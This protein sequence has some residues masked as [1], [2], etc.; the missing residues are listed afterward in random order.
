M[1]LLA[2]C[3]IVSCAKSEN[4]NGITPSSGEYDVYV[5]GCIGNYYDGDILQAV[6]W[7][8]AEIIELGEGCVE[9]ICV[10][11]KDVYALGYTPDADIVL[12]KNGK[13]II[14]EGNDSPYGAREMTIDNGKVYIVGNYYNGDDVRPVYWVNGERKEIN[15]PKYAMAYSISVDNNDIY[16]AGDAKRRAVVW[17]NGRNVVLDG[18][19]YEVALSIFANNNDVYVAGVSS[20][21][22]EEEDIALLW[23]NG[24]KIELD[25]GRN[26][27]ATG[28]FESNAN[29]YVSGYD[30]LGE[31]AV[32]W[33]N[34]KKIILSGIKLGDIPMHT[35]YVSGDEVFLAAFK[36][37]YDTEDSKI[38]PVLWHNG[39]VTELLDW[40]SEGMATSVVA[41]PR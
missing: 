13:K 20:D 41:V 9:S 40:T 33:K 4:N 8:N 31:S 1:K 34:N 12:W 23:K 24:R 26:C 7:K 21:Y 22:Q 29:V 27:F 3:A 19:E 5:G 2:F 17:K 6:I 15:N 30:N 38:T 14:I 10:D 28:V 32:I 25:K 39:K 37:D 11:G 36:A 16:I 18:N 35:L